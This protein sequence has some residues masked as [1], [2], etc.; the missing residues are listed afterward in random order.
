MVFKRK[1]TV[2]LNTVLFENDVKMYGI[3]TSLHSA[4]RLRLFENDVKM[5]GIQTN[6]ST[7]LSVLKFENDVK[8][9]GIQTLQPW[10]FYIRCLRMM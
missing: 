8:M 2:A 3:Q 6:N 4:L 9:Y 5:Y 10:F 1:P 7:S